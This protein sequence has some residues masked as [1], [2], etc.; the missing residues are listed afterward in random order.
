[1]ARQEATETARDPQSNNSMEIL[2]KLQDFIQK[3][4]AFN[5]RLEE[6]VHQALTEAENTAKQSKRLPKELTVS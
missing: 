2:N 5:Q 3:Q 6:R 1:M 4:D